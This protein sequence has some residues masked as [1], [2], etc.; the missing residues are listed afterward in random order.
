MKNLIRTVLEWLRVVLFG[1]E[2]PDV[3]P[4]VFP[5]RPHGPAPRPWG[6][7]LVD[8][9][10]GL[11]AQSITAPQTVRPLPGSGW[12]LPPANWTAYRTMRPRTA[13]PDGPHGPVCTCPPDGAQEPAPEGER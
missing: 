8:A 6:A 12:A 5:G 13:A 9:P 7:E 3:P 11:R 10:R 2:A 1:R 4:V